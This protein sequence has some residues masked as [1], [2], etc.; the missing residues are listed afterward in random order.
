MSHTTAEEEESYL[1][2]YRELDVVSVFCSA[3]VVHPLVGVS[4]LSGHPAFCQQPLQPQILQMTN[5]DK[6]SLM[7]AHSPCQ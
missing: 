7:V 5:D 3:E 6:H 2:T 4:L 1:V